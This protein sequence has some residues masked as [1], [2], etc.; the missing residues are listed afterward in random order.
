MSISKVSISKAS[1]SKD[2]SCKIGVQV[3][4]KHEQTKL[5]HTQ[6]TDKWKIIL[7]SDLQLFQGLT[8]RSYNR[9]LIL[10]ICFKLVT[11]QT[12]PFHWYGHMGH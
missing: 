10:F 2:S 3:G 12:L 6:R 11:L 7:L 9:I 5:A 8:C 4:I 1:I